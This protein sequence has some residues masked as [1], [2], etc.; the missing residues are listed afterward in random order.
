M[1]RMWQAQCPG[2]W[3]ACPLARLDIGYWDSY[4]MLWWETTNSRT[5]ATHYIELPNP[6]KSAWIINLFCVF[7]ANDAPMSFR[8]VCAWGVPSSFCS[9]ALPMSLL[10]PPH[11]PW[12]CTSIE[13]MFGTETLT[14]SWVD[15]LTTCVTKLGRTCGFGSVF[16]QIHRSKVSAK[17]VRNFRLA[18]LSTIRCCFSWQLIF[19]PDGTGRQ[20]WAT[21]A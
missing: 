16:L 19:F 8:M 4:D 13:K 3:L 1:Q 5:L 18:F 21:F 20:Q 11:A 12:S 9:P 10:G 7:F 2:L 6:P 17:F 15:F 14:N